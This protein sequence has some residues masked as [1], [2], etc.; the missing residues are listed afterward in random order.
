MVTVLKHNLGNI[1]GRIVSQDL[2]GYGI[3]INDE[4]ICRVSGILGPQ[5]CIINFEE[6][7]ELSSLEFLLLTKLLAELKQLREDQ[8][9]P[10]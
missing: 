2:G 5:E 6:S 10:S 7:V 1:K 8:S 4:L 3:V 9:W